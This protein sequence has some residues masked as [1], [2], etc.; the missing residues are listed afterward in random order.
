MSE[1]QRLLDIMAK[2]RDP[3]GGCPWDLKQDFAS[4]VPHTLE[5]AYEVADTIE[6]QQWQA[7]PGELGDLLFQ[8]VFYAQLGKERDWF[9]FEQVAKTICDKLERRHPHVFTQRNI[10]ESELKANWEATK[11]QERADKGEHSLLDDLPKALPAL[12]RAQKIQKRVASVGFDWAELPP[13]VEKIY[14]EV[15]EVMAEVEGG[16]PARL[17]DEIGDLLFAV[18]NLARHLKVDPEQA[19]RGANDKF[20]RR[21]RGVETLAAASG[22]SMQ[23]H[24]LD[25]LESYWQQIKQQELP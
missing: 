10:P 9:D 19:L 12:S 24:D 21:F 20:E 25:E 17:E 4:I 2:L 15:D 11:V 23:Q 6:Q 8:V 14:E 5:E 16:D 22:K 3:E 7:L 13:V 1:M 18:T